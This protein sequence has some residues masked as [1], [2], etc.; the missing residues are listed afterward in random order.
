MVSTAFN[1]PITI[2]KDT[3]TQRVF[4]IQ[5]LRDLAYDASLR[6]D[7]IEP[8]VQ[9]L[10]Q[11]L[12]NTYRAFELGDRHSISSIIQ[13][14]GLSAAH[15][16]AKIEI[17]TETNLILSALQDI[18]ERLGHVEEELA[19]GVS[20]ISFTNSGHVH[21]KLIASAYSLNDRVA[22][23]HFGE[24]RVT[25]VNL[26][27]GV[28]TVDFGN[29]G[30]KQVLPDSAPMVKLISGNDSA[31]GKRRAI[32]MERDERLTNLERTQ[33]LHEAMLVRHDEQLAQHAEQLRVLRELAEQQTRN[34]T[35]L[36]DV[37]ARLETTLQAIRD[38]L[39]RGNG[40]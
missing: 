5:G 22:H 25:G 27:S 18:R 34:L 24:G 31:Q 13:L 37:S 23:T 30:V 6:V 15:E 4:D 17:S 10:A 28:L 40:R 36:T 38:I 33:R 16:P 35:I 9:N 29:F 7:T 12:Q 1:K 14:I 3:L 20:P 21:R 2:I 8:V 26:I 32:C 11:R 39:G 19:Q